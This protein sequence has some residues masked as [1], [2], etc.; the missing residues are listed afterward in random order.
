[1]G[2]GWTVAPPGSASDVAAMSWCPDQPVPA[3]THSVR[4]GAAG[5]GEGLH[6]ES[7]AGRCVPV[8]RCAGL[9]R[10]VVAV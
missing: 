9:G 4:V 3:V 2:H 7:V 10:R 8:V 5:R 6:S 1:M